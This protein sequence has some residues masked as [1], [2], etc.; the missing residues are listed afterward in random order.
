MDK[1]IKVN[2]K[3]IDVEFAIPKSE[4]I[5]SRKVYL[6]LVAKHGFLIFEEIEREGGRGRE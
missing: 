1:T 2:F 3:K 6:V 4:M 5:L